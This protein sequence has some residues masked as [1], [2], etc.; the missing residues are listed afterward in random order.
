VQFSPVSC[1]FYRLTHNNSPS[2]CPSL[3]EAHQVST[4]RYS[5]TYNKTTSTVLWL[6]RQC[7]FTYFTAF[8]RHTLCWDSWRTCI[9]DIWSSIN[10]S[11]GIATRY[12]PD[13]RRIESQWRQDFLHPSRP[14]LGPT[15]PPIQR[16]T[17]LFPRDKPFGV[18]RWPPTPI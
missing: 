8:V 18:W 4:D 11:V 5:T 9:Q 13:S 10:S 16:V 12:R 6:I 3:N 15:Q 1:H 17:G 14:A 2:L 7:L